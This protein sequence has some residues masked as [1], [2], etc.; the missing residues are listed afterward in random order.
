ME[1]VLSRDARTGEARGQVAMA[2][3]S[4]AVDAAVRA[5]H[6]TLDALADRAMR[7]ALLRAAAGAVESRAAELIAAADAETALGGPRLTGELARVAYQFR[8]FAD[9]V[10]DGAFL[11]VVIDA[12]DPAAVPP[13]PELRRWKVPL[14]TVAVFAASNFPFAFSVPGGDTASALAAGCPVVVKA[15]PAH[16]ATSELVATAIV[17]A[18]QQTGMPAGVFSLLQS[19]RNNIAIAVVKHPFAKAVAFT[20]SLRAG[21]II[22]DAGA[23][24]PGVQRDGEHES[25]L[26]SAGSVERTR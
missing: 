14:G 6:A 19:T 15:H 13:R 2:A 3:D 23:S 22:F 25:C 16:P 20:G 24:R 5:A 12:P 10:D 1:P 18:A 8:F 7:A 11:G 21:R 4:A 17:K 9:I 26:C